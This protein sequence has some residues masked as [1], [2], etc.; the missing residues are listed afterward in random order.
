MKIK[1]RVTNRMGSSQGRVSK[2]GTSHW[3][4]TCGEEPALGSCRHRIVLILVRVWVTQ[5][6]SLGVIPD[7]FLYTPV[8]AVS[9]MS[10]VG[11]LL[12]APL[13]PIIILT[14]SVGITPWRVSPLSCLHHCP[15]SRT[16]IRSLPS[17][18]PSMASPH[19]EGKAL[20]LTE[21]YR[22]SR[23]L[24]SSPTPFSTALLL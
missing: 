5:G 23:P 24:S 17:S 14:W 19:T 20:L 4:L 1:L 10:Q 8:T 15:L 7:S 9:S 12:P 6:R 22:V 13:W 16:Q 21:A 11:W 2:E 18:H 3:D